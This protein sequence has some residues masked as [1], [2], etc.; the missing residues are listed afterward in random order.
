MRPKKP[1]NRQKTPKK[2]KENK[3]NIIKRKDNK[4]ELKVL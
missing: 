2:T 3:F 1:E 4:K